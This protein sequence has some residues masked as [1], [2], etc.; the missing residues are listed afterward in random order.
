MAKPPIKIKINY[1]RIVQS[2]LYD[3]KNGQYLDL[4]AWPNK[5]GPDQYGNTHMVCQELPREA[6]EAGERGPILGNLRL[7]EDQ[8]SVPV[9][10]HLKRKETANTEAARKWDEQR[11]AMRAREDQ[12]ADA[13]GMEGDEIP[14]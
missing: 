11:A 8:D 5:N 10:H 14:F 9:H 7:P 3:G 12:Q 1:S 13:A 6:R 2:A 4:V